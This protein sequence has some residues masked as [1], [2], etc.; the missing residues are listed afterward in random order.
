MSSIF[1]VAENLRLSMD[2]SVK[3]CDDFYE[4]ACGNWSRD[5]NH[6]AGRDWFSVQ[7]DVILANISSICS[8]FFYNFVSISFPQTI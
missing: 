5:P 8:V 2:K 4:F 3:P 6:K 1:I 7:K